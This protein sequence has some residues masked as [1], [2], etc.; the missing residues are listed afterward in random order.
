MHWR[1]GIKKVSFGRVA[2]GPEGKS[3]LMKAEGLFERSC[4]NL[5]GY[6][7][8][9][10]NLQWYGGYPRQGLSRAWQGYGIFRSVEII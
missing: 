2:A 8:S 6:P 5:K 1:E 10:V 9:I 3:G 4:R 7:R